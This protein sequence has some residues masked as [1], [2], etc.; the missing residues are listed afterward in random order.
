MSN[1]IGDWRGYNDCV[2]IIGDLKDWDI[3]PE[4]DYQGN[5]EAAEWVGGVTEWVRGD[6]ATAV[7]TEENERQ[8]LQET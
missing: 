1:W 6:V 2:V 4:N 5:F 8:K 7:K 3:S